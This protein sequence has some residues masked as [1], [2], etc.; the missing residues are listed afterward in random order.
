MRLPPDKA[1]F[2]IKGHWAA[3]QLARRGLPLFFFVA[4]LAAEGSALATTAQKLS[5]E[6]LVREADLVLRGTVREVSSQEAKDRFTILTTVV[7]TM[8]EQWKGP[9][10]S[11]VILRQPGGTAGEISQ[12]VMGLPE[13]SVGEEL[14]LFLKKQK[15]GHYVTVGEKQG[16]FRIRSNAQTGTRMV[17]DLTGK[18]QEE[19]S[20]VRRVKEIVGH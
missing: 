16:K 5:L 1:C 10:A 17:E 13:F 6:Q 11:T 3:G 4:Y 19:E 20:F 14:I 18:R 12:R 7:V 8:E 2:F 15:D 9:K